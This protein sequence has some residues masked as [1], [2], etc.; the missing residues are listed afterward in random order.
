M[1]SFIW[2]A[3]SHKKLPAGILA[4]ER[5]VRFELSKLYALRRHGASDAQTK[6]VNVQSN[7]IKTTDHIR[8]IS[9]NSDL[10]LQIFLWYGFVLQVTLYVNFLSFIISKWNALV[11]TSKTCYLCFMFCIACRTV[12]HHLQ[13]IV[14]HFRQNKDIV[15]NV[16]VLLPSF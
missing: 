15:I 13:M 3:T 9:K 10:L 7:I 8:R 16:L 1:L 4:D 6:A 2:N 12:A 14:S 11:S 5:E